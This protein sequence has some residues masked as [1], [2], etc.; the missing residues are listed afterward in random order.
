MDAERRGGQSLDV[1]DRERVYDLAVVAVC[2]P[3]MPSLPTVRVRVD[4]SEHAASDRDYIRD[5]VDVVVGTNLKDNGVAHELDNDA[6][7][8]AHFNWVGL[9]GQPDLRDSTH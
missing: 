6:G 4:R 3:A 7:W 2:V 1:D 8:F 5:L 9:S